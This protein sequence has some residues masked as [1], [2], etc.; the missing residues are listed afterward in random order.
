MSC[1][2]RQILQAVEPRVK[3]RLVNKLPEQPVKSSTCPH[4]A[5]VAGLG[6]GLLVGHVAPHPA[7]GDHVAADGRVVNGQRALPA[8]HQRRPV[9]RLDLHVHRGTA[10]H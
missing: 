5:L 1:E 8:Y 7:V 3:Q 6:K 2:K 10:A 4:H 9:Q